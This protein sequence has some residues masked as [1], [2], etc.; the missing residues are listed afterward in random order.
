[1]AAQSI[2]WNSVGSPG[3]INKA[4]QRIIWA[5]LDGLNYSPISLDSLDSLRLAF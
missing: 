4:S 3:I 5:I 1:M 2:K